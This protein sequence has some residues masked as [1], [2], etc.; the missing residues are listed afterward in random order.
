MDVITKYANVNYSDNRIRLANNYPTRFTTNIN[1]RTIAV[2]LHYN[3]IYDNWIV[4]FYEVQAND[5]EIPIVTGLAVLPF[6]NLLIS[7]EYLGLGEFYIFPLSD[8]VSN[9][10]SYYNMA[11]QFQIIWRY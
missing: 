1:G 7:R 9:E 11:D 3:N 10:P 8:Y 5:T 4:D 6:L 2:H